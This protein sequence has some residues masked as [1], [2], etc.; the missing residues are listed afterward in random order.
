MSAW[1][2]GN[3]VA[4]N[5]SRH[6]RTPRRSLSSKMLVGLSIGIAAGLLFGE[7]TAALQGLADAY[8]KLLQMTVLPYVTGSLI[9]GLG[10]LRL[11]QAR[12]V[13]VRVFALL[14]LLWATALAAVFVFP[15]LFPVHQTA[16]FFSTTLLEPPESIDL[17]SLYI[18][19]NPFN[20]L[21]N[22]V[23][24]A[25]VL[26]S[27]LIG[28]AVITLPNKARLLDV[29][30]VINDA[31]AK[32]TTF[33]VA[34]N[35]YGICVI[36]AVAAGT[37]TLDDLERLKVYV[38]SYV[39]LSTVLS[40]W[41]L[42]ALIATLTPVP[43][44]AVLA[45]TRDALITAFMTGSLFAVLPLLVED[46]KTLLREHARLEASGLALADIIVPASFTFP[47]T[48]KLLSLSF[49]LFA[50]WFVGSS[51][52]VTDYPRLAG[53][54]L[55]AS[56]GSVNMSIPFLLDVFRIP[57]DTFQLFLATSVINARFG[58]LISAL[59][60]VTV[61]VIGT[62]AVVGLV[63]IDRR[64]LVRFGTIT[65]VLTV[66][67]I[68]GLRGIFAMSPTNAFDKE[69]AL[70]TM[71]ML[72]E[73][74]AARVLRQAP[75]PA[76]AAASTVPAIDRIHA[77]GVLRVGYFDD[78][79]P[80]AFFNARDELV[81]FDVEMAYQL[82]RDLG[83]SLEFVPVDRKIF[84]GGLGQDACDLVMSG[85]VITADRAMRVLFSA[86]YLDETVAF[87]V[88][89]NKRTAFTDW[90]RVRA[91]G[92]LKIGVPDAPYYIRKLQAELPE[93]HIVPFARTSDLFGDAA[94]DIDAFVLTAERGS[95]YTLLHPDYSVVV[96]QP[97]PAKV[98]LGYVIAGRDQGLANLVN[99]WL[100]LKRKDG[101]IDQLFSRWIL[102]KDAT[103]RAQRW[104]ILHDVLHWLP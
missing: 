41:I 49:I 73:G 38:I 77:S 74:G 9:A 101:T 97:R 34:L 82:A 2:E 88:A 102:G 81:G 15:L 87:L 47:H 104:S 22:A 6:N 66:T 12:R 69:T 96:P 63:R 27:A 19:A 26:F 14:L 99:V 79:L 18:P 1:P 11:E 4:T 103:V 58:T 43:Y 30:T 5:R 56:F 35:P 13:G 94:P 48:G 10:S 68:A 78:S 80:Y 21:A 45:T 57:V 72:R 92:P 24:P 23:V 20:S 54:G 28:I 95:A 70:T 37:L 32:A 67:M 3:K 84:T 8:I 100:D 59:H 46:T 7:R 60:T 44:R 16:S 52:P 31:V 86:P 93:A 90:D 71:H 50:G 39:A 17:V 33:V 98:P 76:P 55:L 85:A 51:L 40:L 53:I 61:A 64:K 36:A 89:D 83:V 62:C 25:V 29:L 42:P 91:M 75:E 65:A